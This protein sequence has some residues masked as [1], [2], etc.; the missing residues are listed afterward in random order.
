MFVH[1]PLHM[2]ERSRTSWPAD[3]YLDCPVN[4][5]HRVARDPAS[6]NIHRVARGDIV[7]P[8]VGTTPDNLASQFSCPQRNPGVKTGIV[9]GEHGPIHVEEGHL[10]AAYRHRHTLTWCKLVQLRHFYK[11]CHRSVSPHYELLIIRC[12]QVR[13]LRCGAVREIHFH[14]HLRGLSQRPWTMPVARQL[15]V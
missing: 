15:P 13:F 3:C 14:T 10:P 8:A 2:G 6:L 4:D 11:V 9:H 12:G 5:L 1:Q 7:S